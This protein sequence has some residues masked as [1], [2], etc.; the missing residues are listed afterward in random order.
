[1][2]IFIYQQLELRFLL[3]LLLLLEKPSIREDPENETG[4]SQVAKE[5]LNLNTTYTFLL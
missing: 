2:K 3:P 5:E 1:M 4:V